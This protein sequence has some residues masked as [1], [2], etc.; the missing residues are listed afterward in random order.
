MHY[1]GSKKKLL[2]F[3]QSTIRS[4]VGNDLTQL[5]FCDLFAGT[6]IVG[7]TFKSKVKEI[8]ANDL[9]YYAYVINR[10]YIGNHKDLAN[11]LPTML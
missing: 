2:P 11:S 8:I 3:I 9:E 5:T 7:R 4:V 1:C 6:G 10:N